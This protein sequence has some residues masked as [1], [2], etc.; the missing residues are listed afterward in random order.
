MSPGKL[1]PCHKFY[2]LPVCVLEKMPHDSTKYNIHRGHLRPNRPTV[3][4]EYEILHNVLKNGCKK[5][6]LPKKEFG[7]HCFCA[8]RHRPPSSP[9]VPH[10]RTQI[11]ALWTRWDQGPHHLVTSLSQVIRE[12]SRRG[13]GLIIGD[14]D[15]LILSHPGVLPSLLHLFLSFTLT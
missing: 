12:K 5:K 7:R 3:H 4:T 13:S 1:H 14:G 2:N 11:H 9:P 10:T 6:D 8:Q 15:I